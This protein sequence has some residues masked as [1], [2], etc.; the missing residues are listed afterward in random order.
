MSVNPPWSASH[1]LNRLIERCTAPFL[2]MSKSLINPFEWVDS[3][4]AVR[5]AACDRHFP[6]HSINNDQ[7]FTSVRFEVLPKIVQLA[8]LVGL[9]I[10]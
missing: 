1:A 7:E 3:T 4:V 10:R 8:V 5:Y 2:G 6:Q 9:K